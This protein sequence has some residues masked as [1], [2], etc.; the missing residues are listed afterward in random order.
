MLFI[1][2]MGLTSKWCFDVNENK[3]GVCG[4]FKQANQ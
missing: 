4:V 3:D 1:L 2:G